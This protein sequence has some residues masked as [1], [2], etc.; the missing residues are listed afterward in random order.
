MAKHKHDLNATCY[1]AGFSF[2]DGWEVA[3]LPEDSECEEFRSLKSV[4]ILVLDKARNPVFRGVGAN[5]RDAV[6]SLTQ[7]VRHPHFGELCDL[8]EKLYA[9]LE[10]LGHG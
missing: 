1:R 6:D 2:N 5:P 3:I 7:D 8:A 9:V 10:I 4:R